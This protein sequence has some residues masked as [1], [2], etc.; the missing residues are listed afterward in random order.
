MKKIYLDATNKITMVGYLLYVI[1]VFLTATGNKN[2][3]DYY[4]EVYMF[5]SN[6]ND[7]LC[8][9]VCGKK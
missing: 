1:I 3:L 6:F 8:L 9:P 2:L 7:Y 4:L 5:Q